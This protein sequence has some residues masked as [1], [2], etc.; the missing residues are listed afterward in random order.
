MADL[1]PRHAVKIPGFG[2]PII[3]GKLVHAPSGTTAAV[4]TSPD[5]A[6]WEVRH[7]AIGTYHFFD[8]AEM[9]KFFAKEGIL[10]EGEWALVDGAYYDG[11]QI[12]VKI[13]VSMAEAE[14]NLRQAFTTPYIKTSETES[15]AQEAERIINGPRKNDY[16]D[17]RM[18]FDRWIAICDVVYGIKITSRELVSIM[19]ALKLSRDRQKRGRDNHVDFIGYDL[20]D[21][22]LHPEDF[23]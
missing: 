14:E 4:R 15:F 5:S 6:W 19:K 7:Q 1:M 18:N 13:G 2:D 21:E 10:H 23:R 17:A 20:L 12:D 3:G 22:Q 11:R 8:G 9:V 16:G